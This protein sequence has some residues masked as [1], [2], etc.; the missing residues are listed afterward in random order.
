MFI[1]GR[2]EASRPS[3]CLRLQESRSNSQQCC[4]GVGHSVFSDLFF[5]T[6]FGQMIKN[7]PSFANGKCLRTSL[8]REPK[9]DYFP[10]AACKD[11]HLL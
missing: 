11:L 4:K 6:A 3:M 2:G 9:V 10:I 5:V 7:S 8:A 1:G